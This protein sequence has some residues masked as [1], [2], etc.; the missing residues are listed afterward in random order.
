LIARVLIGLLFVALAGCTKDRI[1]NPTEGPVAPGVVMPGTLLINE[2]CVRGSN[3]ANEFG[4]FEDWIE[5]YN[6]SNQAFVM[7]ADHW[8]LT[9]D[10]FNRPDRYQIPI[11]VTIP[12][13]GFLVVWADSRNMVG[14]QIHTNFGLSS[15]G[16]HIGLYYNN[17]VTEF[18]VDHYEYGPHPPGG[19]SEGRLPDGGEDFT[20][21]QNPT[22]GGPNQ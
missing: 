9:D 5:I 16:E 6:P 17:G 22:P 3:F 10:G 7:E 8:F 1:F 20:L 19:V 14:E 11:E 21:F 12:A 4:D 15:N 13:R 18:M 2:F